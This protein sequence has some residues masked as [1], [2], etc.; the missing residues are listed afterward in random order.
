MQPLRK[1]KMW[2]YNWASAVWPHYRA[3]TG[4]PIWLRN[5][6]CLHQIKLSVTVWTSCVKAQLLSQ[7]QQKVVLNQ[8]DHPV[9]IHH[10][11]EWCN[12][13]SPCRRRR[14]SHWC[15]C[16]RRRWCPQS[17]F[18]SVVLLKE[19]VV[20]C[21]ATGPP[22]PFEH[23]STWQKGGAIKIRKEERPN[24]RKRSHITLSSE[25]LLLYRWVQGLSVIVTVAGAEQ[26]SHNNR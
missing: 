23:S 14:R 26:N 9:H 8:M 12:G 4:W 21:V 1:W 2:P 7:C 13:S 10:H 19:T 16:W 24:E 18:P 17:P 5:T 22:S 25:I 6:V 20:V 3:T 15:F 11:D